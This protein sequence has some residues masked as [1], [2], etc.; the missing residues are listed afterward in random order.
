MKNIHTSAVI[1]APLAFGLAF[2]LT[3]GLA[4]GTPAHGEVIVQNGDPSDVPQRE[5][6]FADLNLDTTVGVDRLNT[7]IASAVRDVCGQADIR[8]LREFVAMRQC[9]DQ[10]LERA[11]AD[12][13][14]L[15]SARLAARGQPEKL[16][17][18]DHSMTVGGVPRR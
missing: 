7:R 14:A 6:R 15:L 3:F 17:A 18:L 4:F 12:R 11:F 10:S 8:A 9:R 16:A 1:A 13:D 5:V 2:G